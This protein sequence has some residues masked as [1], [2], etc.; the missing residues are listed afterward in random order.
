MGKHTEVAKYFMCF[1]VKIC[2]KLKPK[3]YS[4]KEKPNLN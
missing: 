4:F 2:S 3:A 1:R